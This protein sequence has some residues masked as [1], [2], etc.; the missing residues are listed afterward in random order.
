M[1]PSNSSARTA[2]AEFF[3]FRRATV[4]AEASVHLAHIDRGAVLLELVRTELDARTRTGTRPAAIH[5]IV[6]EKSAV[7]ERMN[8]WMWG[9][10]VRELEL[11]LTKLDS[12]RM[13]EA[14]DRL[15]DACDEARAHVARTAH[16]RLNDTAAA[17]QHCSGIKVA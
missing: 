11:F 15:E 4:Y 5:S 9:E 17:V 6:A 3:E 10:I 7:Y 8:P 14:F 12:R 13:F 16:R 2:A 1:N